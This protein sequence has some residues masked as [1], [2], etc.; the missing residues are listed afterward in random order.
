M[1]ANGRVAQKKQ[2]ETQ[3]KKDCERA[4]PRKNKHSRPIQ[5]DC[6]RAGP[7]KNPMRPIQK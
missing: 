5:N 7:E 3:I 6:E 1:T 2:H 4:G